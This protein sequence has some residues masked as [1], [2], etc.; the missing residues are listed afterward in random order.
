MSAGKRHV[1]SSLLL[2]IACML[3]YVSAVTGYAVWSY[4]EHKANLLAEIDADLPRP[5]GA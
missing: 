3:V 2:R 5:P 4:R 1:S